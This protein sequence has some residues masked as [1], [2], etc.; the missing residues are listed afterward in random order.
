MSEDQKEQE[1]EGEEQEAQ[2]KQLD[3]EVLAEI[4]I[5]KACMDTIL[6]NNNR[7]GTEYLIIESVIFIGMVKSIE[8]LL[9][10]VRDMANLAIKSDNTLQAL[11]KAIEGTFKKPLQFMDKKKKL[12]DSEEYFEVLRQEQIRL[13]TE[14]QSISLFRYGNNSRMRVLGGIDELPMMGEIAELA[15]MDTEN[16]KPH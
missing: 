10:S 4:D 12:I 6:E 7:Q 13:V 5:I 14:L 2:L 8:E 9:T 1:Q 16:K 11:T 15:A 3:L